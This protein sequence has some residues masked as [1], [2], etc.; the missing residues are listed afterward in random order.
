MNKLKDTIP[1]KYWNGE[2][3]PQAS[4]VGELK[5]L[6]NDLPDG[7]PVNPHDNG[8]SLVV[9]NIS[10]KNTHLEFEEASDW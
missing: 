9:Y 5:K 1:K 7:L 2:N 3:H 6:L 4:T 10:L 8:V